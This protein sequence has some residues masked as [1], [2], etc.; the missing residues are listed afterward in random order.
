MEKEEKIK[1]LEELMELDEG[2]LSDGTLLDELDEWDSLSKLSLIA[3][4]KKVFS[5]KMGTEDLLS[6]H[7]VADICNWL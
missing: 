4:A 5:K 2:T 1:L 3:T 6:F 7:T